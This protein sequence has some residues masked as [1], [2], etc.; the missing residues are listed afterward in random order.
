MSLEDVNS[1]CR[2]IFG[3]GDDKTMK[4]WKRYNVTNTDEENPSDI[5]EN[6]DDTIYGAAN[7]T[8]NVAESKINSISLIANRPNPTTN[9]TDLQDYL[10]R[11]D[12]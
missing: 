1:R 11:W 6:T 7:L 12:R 4:D 5:R 3:S 8:L 2:D 9:N 10:E